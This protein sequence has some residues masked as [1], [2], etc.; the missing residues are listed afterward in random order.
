[1]KAKKTFGQLSK[2]QK[3]VTVAKDVLKWLAS[4]KITATPGWYLS[5]D[6]KGKTVN[7]HTC[8]GCAL[9]AV[10]ACAVERNPRLNE[11]DNIELNSRS[12]M[13]RHLAGI[14]SKEQLDAIEDAFEQTQM[15]KG[16]GSGAGGFSR[17]SVAKTRMRQIMEN[18]VDND[19]TFVF[20]PKFINEGDGP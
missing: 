15:Y 2:A 13:H 10:F 3:R 4:G 18:I 16:E 8:E 11:L 14:F 1:M 5:V 19:G 9:G 12:D 7:G 20:T 17:S 6:V